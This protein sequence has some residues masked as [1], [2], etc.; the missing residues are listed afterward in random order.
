M[1]TC[2]ISSRTHTVGA[3]SMSPVDIELFVI[4]CNIK[5]PLCITTQIFFYGD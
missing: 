1:I 4:L 2:L 5:M 3:K